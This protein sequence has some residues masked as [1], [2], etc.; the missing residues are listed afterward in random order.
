MNPSGGLFD[1]LSLPGRVLAWFSSAIRGEIPYGFFGELL[2][3]WKVIAAVVSVVSMAIILASL[4]LAFRH[5]E[6]INVRLS[7]KEFEE[8]GATKDARKASGDKQGIVRKEWDALMKKCAHATEQQVIQLILEADNVADEA[9]KRLGI[10]GEDMGMRMKALS[11]QLE[12]L[13]EF[14]S[15]HKTRNMIAHTPG[16]HVTLRDLERVLHQYHKVL[17]ELGAI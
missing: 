6:K 9:L 12:S 8:V 15:A 13:D 14:W 11:G 7:K 1:T 16:F 4:I 10:P 3:I 17:K 5:R 2:A